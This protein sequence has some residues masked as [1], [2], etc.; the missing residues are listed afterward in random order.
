M[1]IRIQVRIQLHSNLDLRGKKVTKEKLPTN[2]Q[3]LFES[4]TNVMENLDL[5]ANDNK[6]FYIC[7]SLL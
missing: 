6:R 3:Q 5:I 1:R 4:F 7:I 2:F